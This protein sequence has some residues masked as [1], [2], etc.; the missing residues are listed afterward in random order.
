MEMPVPEERGRFRRAPEDNWPAIYPNTFYVVG[1]PYSENTNGNWS[2]T[3]QIQNSRPVYRGGKSTYKIYFETHGYNNWENRGNV[4][5]MDYEQEGT[6]W[7][8]VV[9]YDSPLFAPEV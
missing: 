2:A 7:V 5:E 9:A 8:A 3:G 6:A 4:W 1:G